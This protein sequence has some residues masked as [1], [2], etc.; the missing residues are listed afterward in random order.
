[1]DKYNEKNYLISVSETFFSNVLSSVISRFEFKILLIFFFFFC[2]L[3]LMENNR[4]LM[5]ILV[6]DLI[7]I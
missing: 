5:R 3:I 6:V 1:M 4:A 2:K 7:T